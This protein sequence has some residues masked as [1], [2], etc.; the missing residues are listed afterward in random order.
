MLQTLFTNASEVQRRSDGVRFGAA[1]VALHVFAIGLIA[2]G[3]RHHAWVA[4]YKLPGSAHGTN[5]VVAYLPDRA[6]GQSAAV[7]KAEPNPKDSPLIPAVT[8]RV[9][10]AESPAAV[11]TQPSPNPNATTGADALGSGNITIA[12]TSYFPSPHP[13]LS[14]LPPG[15]RGDVILMATI[16]TDG[17]ISDLKLMSGLG[18]GVDEAV[19][20]TVEQ[21]VFHPALLDGHPVASQQELHFHYARG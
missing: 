2:F 5:F 3:L 6:P 16:G 12:L 18:Y 1:S 20:A 15:T 4:P 19:I 17:K 7:K 14:A 9:A 8:N 10:K 21:W 13:D 11:N